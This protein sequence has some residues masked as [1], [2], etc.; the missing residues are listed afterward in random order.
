MKQNTDKLLR[1]VL[2]ILSGMNK[3]EL[4]HSNGWWETSTGANFGQRKLDSIKKAFEDF[5]NKQGEK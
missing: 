3:C 4:T 2:M 1:K 5:E